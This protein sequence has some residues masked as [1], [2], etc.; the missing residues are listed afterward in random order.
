MLVKQLGI[1]IGFILAIS[2]GSIDRSASKV[3]IGGEIVNPT[4][5]YLILFKD[6]KVIDS[7]QLDH[8]NRFNI[9]F[10]DLEEGLYHFYH[11]PEFNY[12]YLQKGDSLNLRLNTFAFDESLMFSGK[13][14]EVNNFLVELLLQKEAEEVQMN[15]LYDLNPL[16]FD[17][18]IK[19]LRDKKL[20][21]LSDLEVEIKLSPKALDIIKA[22]IDYNVYVFKEKYPFFHKV[23]R[24]THN[25]IKLPKDFYSYRKDLKL[26]HKDLY[27]Y[28]PYYSYMKY[29]LG[30]LAYLNCN[31]NCPQ[32]IVQNQIV[33]FNKHKL[34]VVDSLDIDKR[35]KDNLYRNIAIQYYIKSRDSRENIEDFHKIFSKYSAHNT[36]FNEIED[37]Y[38]NILNLQPK[39][40]V[41]SIEI[42]SYKGIRTDLNQIS[43]NRKVVLYFWSP[44]YESTFYKIQERVKQLEK[45]YPEYIFI[46][47]SPNDNDYR[48][49][50]LVRDSRL[51]SE[52]QFYA[53]QYDIQNRL[54]IDNPFKSIILQDGFI[55]DAFANLLTSFWEE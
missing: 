3:Y 42:V 46:G 47:I 24:K 37:V 48:W 52:Y 6:D 17:L 20:Q 22:S 30:N 15:S 1:I 8:N 32:P 44:N 36:H 23:N 51:N 49:R 9:K 26:N 14:A 38:Q 21:M 12:I 10:K 41:P 45:N 16:A 31:E 28:S 11:E 54:V 25:H 2:C 50:S 7:A 39:R 5:D 27:F 33:H 29:Q 35:L 4:S 53:P 43:K 55:E 19:S 40:E 13:G 18:E 34:F